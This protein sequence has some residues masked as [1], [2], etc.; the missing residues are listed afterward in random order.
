[1]TTVESFEEFLGYPKTSGW[2]QHRRPLRGAAKKPRLYTAA[3]EVFAGFTTI[4]SLLAL[5]VEL[6]WGRAAVG[7]EAAALVFCAGAAAVSASPR[8]A[9]TM[10]AVDVFAL[11]G[12]LARRVARGASLSLSLVATVGVTAFAAAKLVGELK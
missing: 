2:F 4:A 11:T 12:I 8:R 9:P 6:Q 5:A 3:F 7:A 1:M 10:R